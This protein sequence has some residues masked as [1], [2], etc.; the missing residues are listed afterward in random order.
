MNA[1]I[2]I[3]AKD[4]ARK[5]GK[6]AFELAGK[7]R[8]EWLTPVQTRVRNQSRKLGNYSGQWTAAPDVPAA[9]VTEPNPILDP[10]AWRLAFQEGMRKDSQIIL[11]ARV[12]TPEED[13]MKTDK[14]STKGEKNE[15]TEAK[16]EARS[17]AKKSAPAAEKKESKR[18]SFHGLGVTALLYYMGKKGTFGPKRALKIIEK[19]G[20][21]TTAGTVQAYLP[22]GKL[23]KYAK[24]VPVLNKEQNTS[25]KA[26]VEA[27][28][29]IE[30]DEPPRTRE[31]RAADKAKAEK[32]SGKDKKAEKGE[33]SEGSD[34]T[35]T[36]KDKGGKDKKKAPKA[37]DSEP[38]E[39]EREAALAEESARKDADSDD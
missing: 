24:F 2:T 9:S 30:G 13:T 22:A 31:E 11:A 1:A 20:L 7:N 3:L 21:T 8:R 26:I 10:K 4:V 16:G 37:D 18:Q 17:E 6:Q 28:P 12:N 38:T 39:E 19:C 35:P 25:F 15:K 23:E 5:D 33:K 14:K 32:K 36:K 34:K 27:T 29:E